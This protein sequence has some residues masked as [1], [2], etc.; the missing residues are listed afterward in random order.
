MGAGLQAGAAGYLFKNINIQDLQDAITRV[1]RGEKVIHPRVAQALA[2]AAAQA[3]NP[4]FVLY[5]PLTDREQEMLRAIH[6]GQTNKQI[7]QRMGVS[8]GTVKTHLGNLFHK[9]GAGNRT[10]AVYRARHLGL[11]P[12]DS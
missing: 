7:A 3:A 9:L 10:E 1:L 4:R 11:L 8:E 2:E 12:Q 6:E 5:G